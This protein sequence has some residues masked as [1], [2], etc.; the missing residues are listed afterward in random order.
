MS[1]SH[2]TLSETH[3]LGARTR[4]W[5]V[6]AHDC[7]ALA[8]HHIA[9]VGVADAAAP[10]EMVRIDLSGTYM[11]S[12]SGGMGRILLDGRWQTC[13]QGW[14]CLAPPHA[15]L[16][17]RSEPD[18]HWHFTWVRYQQPPDQKPIMSSSSP[19][20]ARFAA[21]PLRHAVLG[22]YHEIQEAEAPATITHWVDIIQT[23]VLRFAQPWQ[24]DDR[25]GHLW[26][27][28]ATRLQEPWS[29]DRLS[30]HCHLSAEHLRRLCRRELGRSPMH[31]VIFLRM[32]LAAKL[33]A[34]TDDKIETIA[35]EVGYENP[36]VFSTTFKKWVGWRPS[37]YRSKRR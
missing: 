15:M 22:L 14:A 6:S 20:L 21:E 5:K 18:S 32:Q 1:K 17:F 25:L 7:P 30:Q 16:A 35:T 2:E 26:E 4:E 13:R 24:T 9:H 28:V 37:E 23:Y 8:L 34:T 11:L 36:F 10:Y 29:L 12:C 31:H 33:L 19:A 3:I 27:Y